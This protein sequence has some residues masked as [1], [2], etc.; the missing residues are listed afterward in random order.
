MIKKFNELYSG[1]EEMHRDEWPD[2]PE[3]ESEKSD[4]EKLSMIKSALSN[5]ESENIT[6]EEFVDKVRSIIA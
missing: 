5:F 4:S 3:I 2:A 6:S 1:G